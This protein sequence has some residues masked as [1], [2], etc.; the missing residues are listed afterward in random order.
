MVGRDWTSESQ[1][2]DATLYFDLPRS[3][4]SRVLALGVDSALRRLDKDGSSQGLF[5]FYTF[6]K[7]AERHIKRRCQ[8]RQ[9]AETDLARTSFE[10]RYMNLMNTRL[11]GEVDLPPTPFLSELPDSVAKVCAHIR[12]HSSMH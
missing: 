9:V 12:G 10:V 2:Q 3:R 6:Q 11:F 5:A 8:S 7:L 4:T 1:L